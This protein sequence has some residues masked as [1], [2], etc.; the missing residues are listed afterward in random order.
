MSRAARA[1]RRSAGWFVL[2]I[3]LILLSI[4]AIFDLHGLLV[5]LGGIALVLGVLT[6]GF[7]VFDQREG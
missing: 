6:A 5:T 3:V 4:P 2:G 1:V 7:T